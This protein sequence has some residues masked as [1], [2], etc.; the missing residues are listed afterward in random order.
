MKRTRMSIAVGL[1]AVLAAGVGYVAR[2]AFAEDAPAAPDKEKPIDGL[3]LVK[4][5]TGNWTT[6]ATSTMGAMTGQVSYGLECGKTILAS[7]YAAK[8]DALGEFQGF[9]VLKFS[10]DGKTAT[11]WWFDSMMD[12]VLMMTGPATDTGYTIEGSNKLGSSKVTLT[13]KGDGFEMK[14]WVEGAEFMTETYT[15][16]K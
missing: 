7:R 14:M 4:A 2:G 11:Q 3:A 12:G 9:G 16:A 5:L 10:A 13:K 6:K 15:K 1:V 8:A